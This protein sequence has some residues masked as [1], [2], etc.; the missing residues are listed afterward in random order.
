MLVPVYV[1]MDFRSRVSSD[2]SAHQQGIRGIIRGILPK[3]ASNGKNGRT[4]D[5]FRMVAPSNRPSEA[6]LALADRNHYR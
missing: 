4:E 6:H 5:T 2:G 3:G 1:M